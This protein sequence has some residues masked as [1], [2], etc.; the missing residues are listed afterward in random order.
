VL[1]SNQF[2]PKHIVHFPG[3]PKK[4]FDGAGHPDLKSLGWKLSWI[5]KSSVGK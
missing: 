1:N 3:E 2:F 4:A 5:F